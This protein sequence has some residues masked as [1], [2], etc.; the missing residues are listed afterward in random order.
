[1]GDS[2]SQFLGIALAVLAVIGGAKFALLLLILG[3]PILDIA[4]V[5]FNRIRRGQHPMQRDE[6]PLYARKTHLHFRLLFGG[7]TTR[8]VC[9]VFYAATI[10]LG[11][12]AL[13]LPSVYKF[14]GIVLAVAIM[15]F[16]LWWS[17]YLQT[18]RAQREESWGTQNRKAQ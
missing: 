18:R 3:I 11:I 6:L 9:L 5:M 2:G 1:M 13:A 4:W 14:L 16:L 7:L 17:G 8:Q 15:A 10:L 12:A